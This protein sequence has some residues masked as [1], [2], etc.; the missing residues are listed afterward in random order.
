MSAAEGQ[1]AADELRSPETVDRLMVGVCGAIWLVLLAVSVI[2]AVALVQ[3]GQGHTGTREEHS[4]WLLYSVIV[5]SALVIIG[6]IPLLLRARRTALTEPDP[7]PEA[8]AEDAPVRP[9][10]A[11]TE[12]LRVFGTS[13]D[14]YA[15]RAD[16][17]DAEPV[18]SIAAVERLWLR[19]SVSLLAS[20]GLGLIAVATATYLL[21]N[22]SDTAAWVALGTAAVITVGTPAILVGFQRKLADVV[23]D[24]VE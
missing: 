17:S 7:A 21:A 22:A 1:K 12:K 24:A 10:E 9:T 6:A 2:A 19:G 13:V 8:P 4:S 14:P 18:V 23:D 3:L 15:R 11:P 5:V 20:M 16:P